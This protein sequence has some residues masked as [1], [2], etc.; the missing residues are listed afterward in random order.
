MTRIDSCK[1]DLGRVTQK[2]KYA[3]MEKGMLLR[4]KDQI[5]LME[6]EYDLMMAEND[7]LQR[8]LS[9]KKGPEDK[10]KK[11]RDQ[12]QVGERKSPYLQTNNHR[13]NLEDDLVSLSLSERSFDQF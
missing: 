5:Q 11:Y 4:Y 13:H 10:F 6:K 12:P 7:R 1:V 8:A 2:L 9:G 3:E